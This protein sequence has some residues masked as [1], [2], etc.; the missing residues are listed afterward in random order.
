[1]SRIS[2]AH[3]VSIV[4][5]SGSA[6][7]A[8]A[9]GMSSGSWANFTMG[10]LNLSLIDAGN[11][12]SII[13]FCA[14]GHWDPL[15][16]KIQF[17]GGGHLTAQKLITWD[18][19]TNQW[20]T[21][22]TTAVEDGQFYH[23]YYHLAL[24]PATGDMFHRGYGSTT[25]KKKPYGGSWSAIASFTNYANQVAGGLEWF[26]AMNALVFIDVLSCQTWNGTS[27]TTRSSSLSG[28]GNY[29]NWIAKTTDYCYFGGGNG[30]TAMYRM[31]SS[32]TITA[33]TATPLQAGIWAEAGAAVP[34]SHPNGTDL[35]LFGAGPTTGTIY[36][37]NGSAWSSIGTMN[38]GSGY[39]QWF[40]VPISTYG[41]VVFIAQTSSVGTP[42]CR[43]YKP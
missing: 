25:V 19:A 43:V 13:E 41:V 3:T 27:W 22:D 15:H 28:L 4:A 35:L 21:P 24:D 23:A 17:W 34:I 36:R 6:L 31:N 20:A 8:L 29:H 33:Q 18:D 2:N 42:I 11:S 30:S 16:R 7:E 32:G 38:T 26:P 39:D 9:T 14:R 12:H 10:G 5:S 37:W 40:A 1:M